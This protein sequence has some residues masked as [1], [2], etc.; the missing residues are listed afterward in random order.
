MLEDHHF[1]C[2]VDEDFIRDNFNEALE[3]ILSS[4]TPAEEDLE[5]EK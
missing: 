3:M 5:D 2:E 4:E 1:F